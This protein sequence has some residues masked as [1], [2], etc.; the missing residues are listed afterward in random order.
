M[1]NNYTLE[2]QALQFG[3]GATTIDNGGGNSGTDTGGGGTGT[4][5][6]EGGGKPHLV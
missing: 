1:K 6:G 3:G 2:E 5:D 4:G